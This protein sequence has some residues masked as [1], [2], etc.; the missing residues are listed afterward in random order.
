[1]ES[2]AIVTP[3]EVFINE[4]LL[5]TWPRKVTKTVT[6]DNS[7]LFAN[8]ANKIDA[9]S[10]VSFPP[11]YINRPYLGCAKATTS[12]IPEKMV[13]Y[14]DMARIE[15]ES[16]LFRLECMSWSAGHACNKSVKVSKVH[17]E[18]GYDD[19]RA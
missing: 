19:I 1:M 4:R 11:E 10:G 15:I 5:N 13:E 8:K 2:S 14:I 17:A 3:L 16:Q 12:Q 6:N 9:V 18:Q 7:I